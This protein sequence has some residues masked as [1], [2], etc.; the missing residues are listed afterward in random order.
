VHRPIRWLALTLFLVAAPACDSVESRDSPLRAADTAVRIGLGGFVGT[1]A[2]VGI[3]VLIRALVEERLVSF[4]QDGRAVPTVIERW[5]P[6]PDRRTWT[7]HVLPGVRFHDD[8][9]VTGIIVRDLLRARLPAALGQGAANI[10]S[11]E[12]SGDD[13]VAIALREPSN[14]LIDGLDLLVEKPGSQL[15]PVGTGAFRLDTQGDDEVML[16]RNDAYRDRT[17]VSQVHLKQYG[18]LRA[19]WADMLRGEVDMLYEVGVDALDFLEGSQTATVYPYQ[20]PYVNVLLLNTQRP[21]FKSPATRRALNAAIDRAA[22]VSQ[23]FYGHGTPASGPIFPFH[24]AYDRSAPALTYDPKLMAA[25]LEFTCLVGDRSLERLA[26]AVQQQLH[27]VGVTMHLEIADTLNDVVA[28]LT[29]GD[30]EATLSDTASGPHLLRPSQFW[31]T[32]GMLNYGK[33]SSAAIDAGFEAIDRAATDDDY[34][35]AVARLQRAFLD[36]PPAVFLAWGERA[37]AVSNRF[38]VPEEPGRDVFTTVRLWRPLAPPRLT[39]SN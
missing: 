27:E 19:A 23:V 1:N 4:G 31:T 20:R 14:F 16:T 35:S 30:F 36:D 22:L 10:I 34:R 9:P 38:E 15:A 12:A 11:I 21:Q 13:A 18:S 25:P 26:L 32:D 29:S 28:R 8:T 2:S 5:N 33:F 37:R 3:G 7:L 6:S 17:T 39:G 24:W